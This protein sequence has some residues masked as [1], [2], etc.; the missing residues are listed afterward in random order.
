MPGAALAATLLILLSGSAQEAKTMSSPPDPA[1]IPSDN[2][3][4]GGKEL[5]VHSNATGQLTTPRVER[6]ELLAKKKARKKRSSTPPPPTN[7]GPGDVFEGAKLYV[8]PYSNAKRQADEWRSSRP[9]DA[10]SLDK[11]AAQADADWFGDWSGDVQK[12]VND[13]VTTIS[14]A[15]ALPVLVAYN[16]PMRDCSGYSG[17]GATSSE[18]YKAWIRS[19]ADGIGSRKAAVILEP[20]AVAYTSC[21]S[22]AD[23][24]T[25]LALIKEGVGVLKAKGNTAVYIDA[26][27]SNWVGAAQMAGR[28]TEAGISGADGFSLNVSNLQTTANNTAYGKDLSSPLGGKHFVIDT[29]RNGLG[30]SPDDQWC[31]PPGRALGEKPTA[32]TADPLVDAYLW[33]K[34]PGESDGTCNGGPPAGTWWPEYALGLAQRATY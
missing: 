24:Q 15:G 25:R 10:A 2:A 16:I 13:R 27:H 19:F 18:A 12:A 21:L 17:G 32:A 7:V 6:V 3:A 20:D 33:V 28:L 34:P 1:E 22:E 8:D 30:P 5:I 31:N 11:I 29:S 26:G 23:K 9:A 14:N 4:S